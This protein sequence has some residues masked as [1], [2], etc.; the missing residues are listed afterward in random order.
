MENSGICASK[1]TYQSLPAVSAIQHKEALRSRASPLAARLLLLLLH[2]TLWLLP[3]RPPQR[4]H[5]LV[6]RL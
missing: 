4:L 6:A 1:N 2:T 3:P 5:V